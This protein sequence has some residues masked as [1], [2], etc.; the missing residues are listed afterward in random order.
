MYFTKLGY[1]YFTKIPTECFSN[2]IM[3]CD[4]TD[5]FWITCSDNSFEKFDELTDDIMILGF[6]LEKKDISDSTIKLD[7][8]T[9]IKFEDIVEDIKANHLNIT[10]H[11]DKDRWNS[12]KNFTIEY[13]K[14]DNSNKI[15]EKIMEKLHVL[16]I[17]TH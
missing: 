3:L 7:F 16:K 6:Y 5:I 9:E 1:E 17:T 8:K 14:G 13:Q 10:L 2:L 4:K 15:I 11:F 12:L